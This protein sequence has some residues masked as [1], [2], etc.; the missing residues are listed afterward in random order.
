MADI[1]TVKTALVTGAM[2]VL[3][4]AIAEGLAQDGCRVV[5]VDLDQKKLDEY[6]GGFPGGKVLPLACDISDFGAVD[7]AVKKVRDAW[8]GVDILVNNAGILSNNKAE[9]T[10][11]EEWRKILAVNLDGAFYFSRAFMGGMKEKGWGRIIIITS[12][13]AKTGGITAGTT[14]SVS[15]GALVSLTFSLAAELA[16]FG[17][18]VNGIAPAYIKTPMITVQLAEEQRRVLLGK[19]PV[20]R[21]CEAEEVAHTVRFLAHPLSGFITGEIIDQNGGLQF[22]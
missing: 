6:A 2:G 9:T 19:I 12:L 14:Y 10:G 3:G 15:K 8:G 18:T 20:G 11:P 16:P 1:K 21:F 5:L 7:A 17:V 4:R 22:D 13:A